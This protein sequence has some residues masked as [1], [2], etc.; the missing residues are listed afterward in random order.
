MAAL[1][2]NAAGR[3]I[4]AGGKSNGQTR[5][6]LVLGR[7]TAYAGDGKA[8]QGGRM[9]NPL[10]E[11]QTEYFDRASMP[12]EIAELL[13]EWRDLDP[14]TA[15]LIRTAISTREP[16]RLRLVWELLAARAELAEMG[17]RYGR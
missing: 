16:R 7:A 13:D 17:Q 9:H 11:P 1:K 5:P 15:R 12:K 2:K 10:L 14:V 8:H 4:R 6:E 3:G